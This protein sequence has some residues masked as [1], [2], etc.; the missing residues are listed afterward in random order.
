MTVMIDD[1]LPGTGLAQHEVREA[2]VVLPPPLDG[3]I[4]GVQLVCAVAALL[5][6]AIACD[7]LGDPDAARSVLERALDLAERDRALFPF[8][9]HP[10]PPQF[11]RHAEYR[12]AP[13]SLISEVVDLLAR[14][15]RPAPLSGERASAREALTRGE[16]RVLRRW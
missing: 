9:I 2:T 15:S 5:L 6:E 13:V 11:E 12:T 16:T 8:L 4:P 3:S 10:V 7:A 14:L 1:R